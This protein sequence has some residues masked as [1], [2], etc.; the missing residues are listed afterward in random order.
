MTENSVRFGSHFRGSITLRRGVA[1]MQARDSGDGFANSASAHFC[2]D[3]ANGICSK[4]FAASVDQTN[5][6]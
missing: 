3:R 4:D 2:F 1:S 6:T 5:G